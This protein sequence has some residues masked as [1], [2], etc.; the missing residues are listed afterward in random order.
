MKD[1]NHKGIGADIM[2]IVSRYIDKPIE[3]VPTNRMGSNLYKI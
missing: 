1:G 3:L 2:K